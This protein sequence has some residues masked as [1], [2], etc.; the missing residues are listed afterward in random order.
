MNETTILLGAEGCAETEGED[1]IRDATPEEVQIFASRLFK[2]HPEIDLADLSMDRNG[3]P[4]F[5]KT[6]LDSAPDDV[7]DQVGRFFRTVRLHL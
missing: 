1:W 3:R 6:I 5:Y 4:Y 7:K 2:Q